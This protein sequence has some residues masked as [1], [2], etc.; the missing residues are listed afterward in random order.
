ME[1]YWDFLGREEGGEAL[2]IRKKIRG[3][4]KSF[5]DYEKKQNIL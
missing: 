2:D 5:V 1:T 4:Q 3:A